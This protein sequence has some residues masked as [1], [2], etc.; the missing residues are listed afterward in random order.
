MSYT[1]LT[2]TDLSERFSNLRQAPL[3][4]RRAPHKP[5]LILLM[6]GR[7]QRGDVAALSFSGKKDLRGIWVRSSLLTLETRSAQR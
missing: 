3:G 4:D 7:Y 5:L 1:S 2:Y 6:L